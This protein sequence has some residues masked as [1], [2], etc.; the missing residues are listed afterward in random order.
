MEDILAE[1]K[2]VAAGILAVATDIAAADTVAVD[3]SLEQLDIA[4]VDMALHSAVVQNPAKGV[5]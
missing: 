2:A 1:D 3:N 5:A 4:V